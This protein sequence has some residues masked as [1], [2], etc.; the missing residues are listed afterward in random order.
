MPTTCLDP[1]RHLSRPGLGCQSVKVGADPS[2]GIQLCR[3]PLQ[4]LSRSGQTHSGEVVSTVTTDK[5]SLGSRDCLCRAVHIPNM[6]FDSHRETCGVATAAHETIPMAPKEALACPG[7][8]GE[9]HSPAQV[10]PGS[11][12]V[13]V[14]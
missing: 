2:A 4:P 10:A 7:C 6:S 1:L 8:P 13:V 3:L 5:D 12:K 11:P 14:G 9:I